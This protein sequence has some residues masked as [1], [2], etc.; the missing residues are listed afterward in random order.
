MINNDDKLDYALQRILRIAI[1]NFIKI[2]SDVKINGLLLSDAILTGDGKIPQEYVQYVV[3]EDLQDARSLVFVI[4]PIV[5]RIQI[6]TLILELKDDTTPI[7]IQEYPSEIELIDNKQDDSL[8]FHKEKIT[9]L[10]KP[11]HYDIL[12]RERDI[13]EYPL[14]SQ[15]DKLIEPQKVIK[16]DDDIPI[17]L[18]NSKPGEELK[19]HLIENQDDNQNDIQQA[20]PN[21]VHNNSCLLYTSPSPRDLSTSRMPSSA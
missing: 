4:A 3:L 8:N 1:S 21:S 10:Y 6:D 17:P 7:T 9:V 15:Y 11:G 13:R 19:A 20:G 2:N 16:R 18:F 12:Y 14:L 5:L